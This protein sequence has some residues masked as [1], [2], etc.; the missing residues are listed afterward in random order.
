VNIVTDALLMCSVDCVVILLQCHHVPGGD[1]SCED[2]AEYDLN[3]ALQL[4]THRGWLDVEDF[5]GDKQGNYP[6]SDD[7][8]DSYTSI[9]RNKNGWNVKFCF[10]KNTSARDVCSAIDTFLEQAGNVDDVDD[11]ALGKLKTKAEDLLNLA[12][13]IR[14]AWYQ[15]TYWHT[16]YPNGHKKMAIQFVVEGEQVELVMTTGFQVL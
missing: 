1:I 8:D 11:E 13:S 6:S 12:S 4:L 15:H 5:I 14:Y 3:Q 9:R 2:E 7:E 16:D 10:N